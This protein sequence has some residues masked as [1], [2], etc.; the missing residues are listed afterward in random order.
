MH[1]LDTFKFFLTLLFSSILFSKN[2]FAADSLIPKDYCH[3]S[4]SLGII[5]ERDLQSDQTHYLGSSLTAKI[6]DDSILTLTKQDEYTITHTATNSISALSCLEDDKKI[7]IAV[8]YSNGNIEIFAPEL[9]DRLATAALNKVTELAKEAAAYVAPAGSGLTRWAKKDTRPS[10]Y[11]KLLQTF[12]GPA[13][14]LK[15]PFAPIDALCFS[16]NGKHI[17]TTSRAI[18][19]QTLKDGTDATG[20]EESDFNPQIRLITNYGTSEFHGGEAIC[21][22]SVCECKKNHV[23]IK[24]TYQD[25][26][27]E[28]HDVFLMGCSNEKEQPLLHAFH[29]YKNGKQKCKNISLSEARE[30]IEQITSSPRVA[31]IAL[32]QTQNLILYNLNTG[33]QSFI[34]IPSYGL[35]LGTG[36]LSFSFDNTLLTDGS[37]FYE[38]AEE[39]EKSTQSPQVIKRLTR[40]ASGTF[41]RFCGNALIALSKQPTDKKHPACFMATAHFKGKP[42]DQSTTNAVDEIKGA[43][44]EE[45]ANKAADAELK[46]KA[47]EEEEIEDIKELDKEI[48]EVKEEEYKK[49]NQFFSVQPNPKAESLLSKALV[50]GS[51]AVSQLTKSRASSSGSSPQNSVHEETKEDQKQLECALKAAQDDQ[52]K[53]NLLKQV[54]HEAL[55]TQDSLEQTASVKNTSE[56]S[57]EEKP[58]HQEALT[59]LE[60]EEETGQSEANGQPG[61]ADTQEAKKKKKR[62]GGK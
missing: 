30:T 59:T 4:S 52:K 33:T 18:N 56:V 38:W 25:E 45:A 13:S 10:Y 11:L 15:I 3:T 21:P 28:K 50:A 31:L 12:N 36:R 42:A 17:F 47:E 9:D 48:E 8:G 41:Y 55:E 14:V 24:A 34:Q 23:H 27:D 57:L 16:R 5:S 29:L 22:K 37:A 19:T 32:T 49:R 7:L 58:Q 53:E 51:I 62:K 35:S 61:Q 44:E 54:P 26:G 39:N 20:Y 2:L 40:P 60:Q 6:I 46:Q 1:S 43:F